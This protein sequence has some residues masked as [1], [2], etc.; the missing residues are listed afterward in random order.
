M[1]DDLKVHNGSILV[2]RLLQLTYISHDALRLY[3]SAKQ[4][5]VYRFPLRLYVPPIYNPPN[6]RANNNKSMSP[7]CDNHNI[8][9]PC[10]YDTVLFSVKG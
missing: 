4:K 7:I 10:K 9:M 6:I 8:L 2:Q 5:L 3:A 1:N